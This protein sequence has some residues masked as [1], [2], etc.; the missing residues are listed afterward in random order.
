MI[1]MVACRFTDSGNAA[2]I[3]QWNEHYNG[4]KLRDLLSMDGVEAVQRFHCVHETMSP[5]IALHTVPDEALAEH[6]LSTGSEG[7]SAWESSMARCSGELFGGLDAAPT[8]APDDYLLLTEDEGTAAALTGI[9]FVWLEAAG[10]GCNVEKRALAIVG[11]EDGDDLAA[12]RPAA[13]RMYKPL[14]P[15]KLSADGRVT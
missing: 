15:Q 2:R 12:F 9:D 8:V 1:Y 7:F 11:R 13:L 10:P 14:Q 5:Y 4:E 6:G 3:A